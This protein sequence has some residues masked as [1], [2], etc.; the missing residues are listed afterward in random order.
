M[1]PD[2]AADL[3]DI[4]KNRRPWNPPAWGS[5]SRFQHLITG[6]R[7]RDS[8]P[9]ILERVEA[10]CARYLSSQNCREGFVEELFQA[11]A[12]HPLT[13][14][15]ARLAGRIHGEQIARGVSID[16]ADL[17]V[18]ATALQLGFDIVTLSARH[19]EAIPGLKIVSL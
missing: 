17:I 4:A 3:E 1:D 13:L 16:F 11:V 15:L 5:S 14:E 8:V 10:K 12:V 19:F 2:F 7:R 6:E 18:G 9:E